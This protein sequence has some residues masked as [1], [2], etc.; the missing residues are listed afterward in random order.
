MLLEGTV[1]RVDR[2]GLGVISTGGTQYPFTFDK[3][4]GYRGEQPWEYGLREGCSVKF[5]VDAE[6]L[7]VKSVVLSS[8]R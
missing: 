3:L 6:G 4:E 8:S 5:S 2:S 7:I 1:V